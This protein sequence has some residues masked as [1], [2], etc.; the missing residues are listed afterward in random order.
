MATAARAGF[1]KSIK[2]AAQVRIKLVVF[3]DAT[4]SKAEIEQ[5]GRAIAAKY[6]GGVSTTPIK[7]DERTSEK[8]G[9]DYDGDWH[10]IKD[11]A[12][13]TII[14]PTLA[15]CRSVLADLKNAF[16]TPQGAR[17]DPVRWPS[18]AAHVDQCPT[19]NHPTDHPGHRRRG[20]TDPYRRVR[21]L[22]P[23]GSLGLSAQDLL[24]RPR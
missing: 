7:S 14:V 15:N 17:P 23:P 21:Y 19:G 6:R 10:S 12:R 13:M 5:V 8:D 9:T 11:L 4:A 16:T 1:L 3:T 20:H 2:D 22:C 18:R 24:S